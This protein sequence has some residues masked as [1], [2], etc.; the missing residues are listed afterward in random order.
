MYTH[1][2]RGRLILADGNFRLLSVMSEDCS[3]REAFKIAGAYEW[4]DF[5]ELVS[6]GR[7]IFFAPVGESF[8]D[9]QWGPMMYLPAS[10]IAIYDDSEWGAHP[11]PD[12]CFTW[13][14]ELTGDE[15]SIHGFATAIWENGDGLMPRQWCPAD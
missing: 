14:E 11:S 1:E 3:I 9:G 10:D 5:D 2:T 12:A 6:V 4:P 13:G 8:V 15:R 7:E